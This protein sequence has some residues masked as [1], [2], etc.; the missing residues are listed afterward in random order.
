M[1]PK[2][3]EY[4]PRMLFPLLPEAASS[5]HPSKPLIGLNYLL[6]FSIELTDSPFP[7]A[8]IP[9]NRAGTIINSSRLLGLVY[10]EA[11]VTNQQGAA[12]LVRS[13]LS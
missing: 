7:F 6:V 9:N 11:M 2:R 13:G 5:V 8:S 10:S 1:T 4:N 12:F 3:Y